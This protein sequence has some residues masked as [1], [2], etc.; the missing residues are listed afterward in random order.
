MLRVRRPASRQNVIERFAVRNPLLELLRAGREVGVLEFLHLRF[1]RVHFLY[2]LA[3]A[4]QL[5][6]V[7]GAHDLA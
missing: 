2:T 4:L 7:L 6:L 1:E 5:A 3:Y